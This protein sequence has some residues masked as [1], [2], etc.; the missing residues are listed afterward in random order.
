MKTPLP[1]LLATIFLT[2]SA[3]A[4]APLNTAQTH[5]EN[6]RALLE[7]P[8]VKKAAAHENKVSQQLSLTLSNLEE[9]RKNK[10]SHLPLAEKAVKAAQEEMAKGDTPENRAKALEYVKEALKQGEKARDIRR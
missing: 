6:A 5:L 9:T 1:S 4:A 3:F 8:N 7:R 2:G 10:G